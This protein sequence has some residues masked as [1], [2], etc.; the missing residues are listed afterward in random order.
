MGNEIWRSKER[1]I[2]ARYAD[3]LAGTPDG[4]PRDEQEPG[5]SLAVSL[6]PAAGGSSLLVQGSF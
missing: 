6:S 3:R 2:V 5:P 1:E 4:L